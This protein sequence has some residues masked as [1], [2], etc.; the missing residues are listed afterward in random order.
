[1]NEQKPRV[2]TDWTPFDF[3]NRAQRITFSTVAP[4]F[5][6]QMKKEWGD[7][8]LGELNRARNNRDIRIKEKRPNWFIRNDLVL[9][10][11]ELRPDFSEL[12]YMVMDTSSELRLFRGRERWVRDLAK[13]ARDIRNQQSH[14]STHLNPS[15]IKQA[16]DDIRYLAKF[17]AAIV[18]EASAK[19]IYSLTEEMAAWVERRIQEDAVSVDLTPTDIADIKA[20]L[21]ELRGNMNQSSAPVGDDL[22]SDPK[23]QHRPVGAAR[24]DEEAALRETSSSAQKRVVPRSKTSRT[25]R[26]RNAIPAP[27]PGLALF[28]VIDEMDDTWN[29]IF[30]VRCDQYVPQ[31]REPSVLRTVALDPGQANRCYSVVETARQNEDRAD[32]ASLH[33]RARFDSV[34]FAG[35]SFGLAL[36]I[37]DRSVRYGYSSE[38]AGRHIIATGEILKGGQ[39]EVGPI[40]GLDAKVRL[41]EREA[42]AGSLFIFPKAN[43]AGLTDDTKEK[44]NR[45]A[46]RGTFTWRAIGHVRELEDLFADPEDQS[47]LPD[48]AKPE[49][50]SNAPLAAKGVERSET[51]H[52]STDPV[53]DSPAK[54][55]A[56]RPSSRYQLVA[57]IAAGGIVLLGAVYGLSQLRDG[58][59][60]DP[61]TEQLDKERIEMMRRLT[62]EI[63]LAPDHAGNCTD[64]LQA[65]SPL[66][67]AERQ[68]LDLT[69]PAAAA[70]SERCRAALAESDQRLAVLAKAAES[71]ARTGTSDAYKVF[72]A[73]SALTKFDLS[74][75]AEAEV[76]ELLTKTA[77]S[78]TAIAESN[79][80]ISK[81]TIAGQTNMSSVSPSS[82]A[83]LFASAEELTDLDQRRLDAQ[84]SAYLALAQDAKARLSASDLRLGIIAS[85]YRQLLKENT[86]A[87]RQSFQTALQATTSYDRKRTENPGKEGAAAALSDGR[88]LVSIGRI[89]ELEVAVAAYRATPSDTNRKAM[90]AAARSLQADDKA[91]LTGD[92]Q[93]LL[94]DVRD[95]EL[96]VLSSN[97]RLRALADADQDLEQAKRVESGIAVA[98]EALITAFRQLTDFDLSRL[99]VVQQLSL[100]AA[101][102]AEEDLLKSD[103]RIARVLRSAQI[104]L[105]AQGQASPDMR[106]GLSAAF[107]DLSGLDRERMTPDQ[108][109]L[110]NKA[111]QA[112]DRT[113]MGILQSDKNCILTIIEFGPPTLKPSIP[114]RQ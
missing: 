21:V 30:Y 32:L 87:S 80:R 94:D 40:D 103:L 51:E 37:A 31:H 49:H 7:N 12:C 52:N 67:A 101:K 27:S 112:N 76:S 113:A 62:S 19:N 1:M 55:K 58:L 16:E 73:R 18:G 46:E 6:E 96:E 77:D 104:V 39:G 53:G 71:V 15:D 66:S 24:A 90:A 109:A 89:T 68:S 41:L 11:G 97:A 86:V 44:L 14:Y 84:Q 38:Y 83:E 54:E 57:G 29:E 42:Q 61:V 79:A 108:H 2:E 23:G 93:R 65:L 81:F 34:E 56:P 72:A 95:S 82:D 33:V 92:Q 3:V 88:R 35:P 26:R 10:D 110:I 45:A 69:F 50:G 64:L 60:V 20:L 17:A 36:A 8:W 111:C 91:L 114:A 59:R 99:D 47:S 70:T 102:G 43:L 105:A 74:R 4:F 13:E 78:G 106:T 100:E 22:G 28:P 25:Q 98:T 9:E 48:D 85:A 107:S 5:L 63:P 75:A